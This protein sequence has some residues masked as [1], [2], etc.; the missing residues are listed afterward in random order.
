MG[1]D[2]D[3]KSPS[4]NRYLTGFTLMEILLAIA[5]TAVVITIVNTT[6]FRS[7]AAIESVNAERAVYQVARIAMN[8][9]IKDIS[10]AYIPS[11]EIHEDRI[12]MYGFVGENDEYD[13]IDND[14]I[15]L[16]SAA[17]I[18]LGSVFGGMCEIGYYLK[19]ME[20]KD[21]LFYLMRRE[22]CR[23]DNDITDGGNIME[24]AE[25][26]T[27]LNIVYIDSRSKEW[28]RWDLYEKLYLPKQVKITLT[29]SCAD[30]ELSFTGVAS[31][32]LG[33][34]K[35]EVKKG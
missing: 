34:R 3:L 16:T 7:H 6:F 14:S 9:M 29:F 22:D 23:P 21:G 28:D 33:G 4:L 24:V 13:G 30:E 8:R 2:I 5:I 12:S 1:G 35:I 19:E 26:L 11:V 31:L 27:G 18:G 32:P 20:D 15:S 10:C 17:N 25:G